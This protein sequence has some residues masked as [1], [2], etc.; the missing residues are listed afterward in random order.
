MDPEFALAGFVLDELIGFG[1]TGEVWRAHDVVTGETVALKRLRRRGAGGD[2]AASA[3]GGAARDASR[4][5]H[6]IGMR[7][8]IVEGDEA[9]LVMDYAAGG[10][11][12]DV[13]GRAAAGCPRRRS[14]PCSRRS[15]PRLRPPTRVTW[16]T[17]T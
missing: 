5:P 11:L 12:A 8:L 2:R 13:L 4:G 15:R 10:S 7:Q 9:V 16:C 6:V 3:R 1:G 17:A 14:S